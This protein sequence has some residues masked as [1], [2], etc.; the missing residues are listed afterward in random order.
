D[1]TPYVDWL[2]VTK[3]PE[4]VA[5]MWPENILVRDSV[6]GRSPFADG[7]PQYYRPNVWILTSVATQVDADRNLPHLVACR[8]LAPALGVSAEPLLEPVDFSRWSSSLDWIITGG[9]SGHGARPCPIDAIRSIVDQCRAASVACF[10]KQ[11]GAY[12]V[13]HARHRPDWSGRG[14]AVDVVATTVVDGVRG[15]PS[16]IRIR[17]KHA[18][19]GDAEEWP[20]SLRVREFPEVQ[21]AV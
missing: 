1:S 10:V 2:L 8:D 15:E 6:D 12:A 7:S 18:K 11:L 5:R 21:V 14:P 16:T 3:R 4:N 17:T 20:R 19:G 9:E 13:D